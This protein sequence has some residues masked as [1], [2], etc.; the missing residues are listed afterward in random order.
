MLPGAAGGDAPAW[1]ALQEAHL[2]QVW[3]VDIFQGV[4]LLGHGGGQRLDPDRAAAKLLDQDSQQTAVEF[5]QAQR[6]HFQ[7]RQGGGGDFAADITVRPH[8][9]EVP[10]PLEQPV[11]DARRPA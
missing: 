8:L 5:I 1:S 6:V 2:H 4:P 3:L 9:C 10:D 7:Q 11:G